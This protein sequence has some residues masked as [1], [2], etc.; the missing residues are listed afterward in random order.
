M[1]ALDHE[2]VDEFSSY[3]YLGPLSLENKIFEDVIDD[4][5]F[6]YKPPSHYLV[7]L[8]CSSNDVDGEELSDPQDYILIQIP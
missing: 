8:V 2:M 5:I 3:A 4:F 7:S 1:H 6:D